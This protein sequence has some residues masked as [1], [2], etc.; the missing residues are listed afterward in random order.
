M[1]SIRQTLAAIPGVQEKILAGYAHVP[2]SDIAADRTD[3]LKAC[4][5]QFAARTA[6]REPV[7]AS[8]LAETEG[9]VAGLRFRIMGSGPPLVLLPLGLAPTQWDALVPRLAES[10]C[11]IDVGGRYLGAV[12]A[13]EERGS[14]W[15]YRHMLAGVLDEMSLDSGGSVLEIGSGSGIVCRWLAERTSGPITGVDL[16]PYMVREARTLAA[17]EGLSDRIT[18]QQGNAEELPFPDA[19]FAATLSVTVME[20]VDADRALAEMFRVTKPGENWHRGSRH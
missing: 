19:S 12:A 3:E 13:L 11:V 6:E 4:I 8:Q 17:S 9:E 5:T 2:W 14:T 20:E 16:S 1:P 15:G 7:P 10:F 18:F